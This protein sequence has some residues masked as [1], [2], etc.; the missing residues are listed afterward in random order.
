MQRVA[1]TLAGLVLAAGALCVAPS[2]HADPAP[3]CDGPGLP[4]CAGPGPLTP[5]QQ[6]ALQ[7]WQH[8]TPCNWMP[9]GPKVPEGTPG[10]L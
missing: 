1:L 10:S 2:A 5:E 7:A 9:N 6:C 3:T 8:W 4:P